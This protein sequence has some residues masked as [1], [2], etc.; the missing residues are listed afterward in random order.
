MNPD[1]ENFNNNMFVTNQP[2]IKRVHPLTTTNK[3]FNQTGGPSRILIPT[4]PTTNNDYKA[5]DNQIS[6]ER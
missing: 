2:I 1:E 3:H 4:T 5:Y 6:K